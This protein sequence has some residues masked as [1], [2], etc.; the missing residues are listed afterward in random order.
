[1]KK[2][3]IILKHC[4]N[5][6]KIINFE[7][8]DDDRITSKLIEIYKDYIDEKARHAPHLGN[9]LFRNMAAI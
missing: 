9:D 2:N 8:A 1:M 5:F 3:K 7:F 4:P 6:Y